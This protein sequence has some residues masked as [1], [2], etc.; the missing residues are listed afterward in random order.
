[1]QKVYFDKM[2]LADLDVVFQIEVDNYPIYWSKNIMKDCINAGYHCITVKQKSPESEKIIGYAFLMTAYDESHLLNMCIDYRH[3]GKGLG[4]KLLRYL[5]TICQ[6]NKSQ[7]FLLEVRESNPNAQHLYQS[8][9]FSQ[10]GLRKNYYK[11]I[12]GREHAIVMTKSLAI[13][14]THLS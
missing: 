14:S 6:Y 3:Q 13:V 9:G 5:E 2:S 10:I 8:F 1:M 7:T 11:C 12:K 4:R